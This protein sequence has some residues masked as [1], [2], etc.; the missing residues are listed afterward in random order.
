MLRGNNRSQVLEQ[1]CWKK[2]KQKS[3]KSTKR[4]VFLKNFFSKFEDIAM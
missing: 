4:E 1:T 2:R 3:L